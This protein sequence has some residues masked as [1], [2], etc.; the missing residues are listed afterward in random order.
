MELSLCTAFVQIEAI[1][2]GARTARKLGDQLRKFDAEIAISTQTRQEYCFGV[3]PCH[4]HSMILIRSKLLN[5]QR[6]CF[7]RTTKNRPADPPI[8]QKLAL[9]I[10]N[11]NFTDPRFARFQRLSTTIGRFSAITSSERHAL[12]GRKDRQSHPCPCFSL[13]GAVG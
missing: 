5:F 3:V 8:R 7:P 6:K 10:S 12:R 9:L 2:I 13:R 11:T 1:A 4:S